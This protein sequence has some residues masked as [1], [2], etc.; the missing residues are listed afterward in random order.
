MIGFN[1]NVCCTDDE[2]SGTMILEVGE[3]VHIICRRLFEQDI[4]RHF[5]GEVTRTSEIAVLVIGYEFM[6]VQ[7]V[8]EFTRRGDKQWRFFSLGDSNNIITVIPKSVNVDDV[9]YSSEE[10]SLIVTDGK[11]FKIHVHEFGILR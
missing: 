1:D 11:N 8:N 7:G 4:R 2:R 9:Y 6:F 5:V 3:N 10:K